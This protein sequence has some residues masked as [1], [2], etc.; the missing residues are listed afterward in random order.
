MCIIKVEIKR[1]SLLI[2]LTATTIK[3][4]QNK[5]KGVKI[6][7]GYKNNP[8]KVFHLNKR[9]E[10]QILIITSKIYKEK[11]EIFKKKLRMGVDI[12]GVYYRDR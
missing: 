12:Q 11:I 9:M 8:K 2:S 10:I 6:L 7:T 5:P 3:P 4:W 1:I